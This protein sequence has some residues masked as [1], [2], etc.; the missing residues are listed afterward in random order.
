M[1]KLSVLTALVAFLGFT[2]ASVASAF[3]PIKAKPF[4]FD[5]GD[6]GTS[7]AAWVTHQ[8]LPD[9][10]KSNHA[11]FLQKND[12]TTAFEAAGAVIEGVAGIT[13]NSLSY[14]I[15]NDAHCGAGAPRFN[16][17]DVLGN[18]YFVGGCANGT[19]TPIVGAPAPGWTH[20]TFTDADFFPQG[21]APACPCLGVLQVGSITILFDEG[22]DT[23]LPAPQTSGS[24]HTDNIEVNGHVIRK[25]GNAK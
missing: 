10:G 22:T 9:A 24:A 13:L 4:V 8:G 17:T 20:V 16:V 2:L 6:L 14:D 12:V 15:R 23:V 3:G 5:P 19:Q 7:T 11:L 25:P 1:K 18:L 21:A